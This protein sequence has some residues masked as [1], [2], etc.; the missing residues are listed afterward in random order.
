MNDI[1]VE[2]GSDTSATLDLDSYLLFGHDPDDVHDFFATLLLRHLNAL[3]DDLGKQLRIETPRQLVD[4]AFVG[5]AFEELMLAS[6]GVPRDAVNLAGMAAGYAGIRRIQLL[7]CTVLRETTICGT[8]KGKLDSAARKTL[9]EFIII[10]FRK[11]RGYCLLS[12]TD[13]PMIRLVQGLYDARLIHRVRQGISLDPDSHA[14]NFGIYVVDFGCFSNLIASGKLR[15][16]DDGLLRSAR[17]VNDAGV[18][19]HTGSG[20]ASGGRTSSQFRCLLVS[21][22]PMVALRWDRR[23][24][25]NADLMHASHSATGASR[26]LH[27]GLGQGTV[28]S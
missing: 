10:A 7:M 23:A 8:K 25:G 4:S 6:E 27:V 21:C 22:E 13:S 26:C 14:T 1:G 16:V 17:F 9:N 28:A 18:R 19:M 20:G 2:L 11:E 15:L 24:P 3:M 5:N 12:G